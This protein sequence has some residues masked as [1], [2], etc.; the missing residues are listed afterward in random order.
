LSAGLFGG[1]KSNYGGAWNGV[2]ASVA[3]LFCGGASQ[4]VAQLIGVA[5]SAGFVFTLSFIFA[6]T[7]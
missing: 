2:N 7:S 6:F 5:T 4:F 3:A 1:G